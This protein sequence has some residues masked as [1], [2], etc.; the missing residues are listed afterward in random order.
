MWRITNDFWDRWDHLYA[1]F[2]RC[3]VWETHVGPGCW[4]DC[5][6]LPLGR[7]QLTETD[8]KYKDRNTRFTQDEQ[9]TMMALWCLFRSP[10]MIGAEMRLNDEFTLSLLTNRDLLDY[11]RFGEGAVPVRFNENE[12]VWAGKDA[13]GSTVV[14]LFNISEEE[15]TVSAGLEELGLLARK[16]YE[17]IDLFTKE[18]ALAGAE[19]SAVLAPHACCVL[20]IK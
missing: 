10:L 4:P 14:G 20:R 19:V 5:D 7:I 6:M 15:K 8:P 3:E 17:T 1:M 12:A 16:S 13:D 9:K 18:T 2:E 11:N